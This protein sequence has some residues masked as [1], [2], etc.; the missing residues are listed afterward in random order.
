M[1]FILCI[2]TAVVGAWGPMIAP[3]FGV[4]SQEFGIVRCLFRQKANDRATTI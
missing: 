1:L 4:M 3:G 2:D